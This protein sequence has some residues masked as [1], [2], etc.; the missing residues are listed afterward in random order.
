M[1]VTDQSVLSEHVSFPHF[2]SQCGIPSEAID[3]LWESNM[4]SQWDESMPVPAAPSLK[5][6]DALAMRQSSLRALGA[7]VRDAAWLTRFAS[8]TIQPGLEGLA[9]NV[10]LPSAALA[11]VSQRAPELVQTRVQAEASF[12]AYT[13][14]PA[15]VDVEALASELIEA[16]C[17]AIV[18]QVLTAA[19]DPLAEALTEMLITANG[20]E[21]GR[22]ARLVRAGLVSSGAHND[23]IAKALIA[24]N[25]VI[26][27][28]VMAVA[29]ELVASGRVQRD[30]I[31][32]RAHQD[33]VG[34]A[35]RLGVF[36]LAPLRQR[37]PMTKEAEDVLAQFEVFA[38]ID[39]TPAARR[40][41]RWWPSLEASDVERILDAAD[42]ETVTDWCQG[43]MQIA[44]DAEEVVEL[45]ARMNAVR[46]DEFC[47]EVTRRPDPTEEQPAL[48][49]ALREPLSKPWRAAGVHAAVQHLCAEL[50]DPKHWHT[51]IALLANGWKSTMWELAACAKQV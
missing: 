15:G 12:S 19:C 50:D 2:I 5:L 25:G 16:H 6:A 27:V 10:M 22:P 44:P 42:V 4:L 18:S 37:E 23:I 33:A 7:S 46:F 13:M 36:E 34:M 24:S 45:L 32:A 31:K 40:A 30:A 43:A 1:S 39:P 47:A 14:Q 41:I 8:S 17:G 26:D 38:L 48:A 29:A 3:C 20:G 11:L 35:R 28:P 21:R 49:I 51:A 9:S